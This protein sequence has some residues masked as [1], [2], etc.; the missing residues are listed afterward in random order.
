MYPNYSILSP[1]I[2]TICPLHNIPLRRDTVPVIY[3]LFRFDTEQKT[4]HQAHQKLFPKSGFFV[5]GG[6]SFDDKAELTYDIMYCDVCR[7]THFS[8]CKERDITYGLPPS[9]DFVERILRLYCGNYNPSIVV[10]PETLNL[11]EQQQHVAAIKKLKLA[12]PIIPIYQLRHYVRYQ[13]NKYKLQKSDWVS[14]QIESEDIDI[15]C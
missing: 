8:W 15:L 4:E 1:D 12:N 9:T 14:Y 6:C 7:S 10:S 3:G 11:I 13:I 5:F 2:D